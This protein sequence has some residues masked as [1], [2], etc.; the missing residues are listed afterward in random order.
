MQKFLRGAALAACCVLSFGTIRVVAQATDPIVGSW[1]LNVARSKYSPGP[2]L[3]SE[4]R[5]YV[6]SGQEI[7]ASSK[8]VDGDGKPMASQWTIN[9]D[10]KDRALTGTPDA[11]MLSLK[12]IDANHA[13]FMQKKAGKIVSTGTRVISP[14]GRMMTIAT[15][16]TDAS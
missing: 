9:Y 12:R 3:K 15:K 14:D 2:T 1:E 5:T 6:V 8:G 7:K 13:E 16:G 11:D 10:G 4:S